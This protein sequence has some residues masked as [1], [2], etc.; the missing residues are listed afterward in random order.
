VLTPESLSQR[1]KTW[2]ARHKADSAARSAAFPILYWQDLYGLVHELKSSIGVSTVAEIKAL[3]PL[4]KNLDELLGPLARDELEVPPSSLAGLAVVSS[5]LG[6]GDTAESLGGL[7][8]L[9]V[10]EQAKSAKP[11]TGSA[12]GV[13]SEPYPWDSLSRARAVSCARSQCR[14]ITHD[15]EIA[16]SGLSDLDQRHTRELRACNGIVIA[17]KADLSPASGG[18]AVVVSLRTLGAL[19][20]GATDKPAGWRFSS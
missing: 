13:L 9:L 11:A 15:D 14:F 2:S 4:V 7:A 19:A 5:R 3:G 16:L 18:A 17:R 6:E 20:P 12:P 1:I 10:S 8:A